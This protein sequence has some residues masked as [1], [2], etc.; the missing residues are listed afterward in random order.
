MLTPAVKNGVYQVSKYGHL[1]YM[2]MHPDQKYALCADI[3][4]GGIVWEP[5][6]N[7]SGT[8]DGL[9]N[10]SVYYTI[11]NFKLQAAPGATDV[12]FFAK[13]TGTVKNI[14][15]ADV[16]VTGT[17]TF[18]GNAGVVAGQSSK[19]FNNVFVKNSSMSLTVKNANVG[20]LVGKLTSYIYYGSTSGTMNVTLSGGTSYVGGVVGHCTGNLTNAESRVD[21]TVSG[22]GTAGAAGGIVG[23]E[24]GTA[25]ELNYIAKM[26]VNAD[27]AFAAGTLV[28][29][30]GG[31]TLNNSYNC[32]R[33][34]SVTGASSASEYCG[35][36]AANTAVTNC[37]TRDLSN[38]E[39]TLSATEYA[40]RKKVVDHMY[41]MCTIRWIPTKT[42]VIEASG[43]YRTFL[44]G[45]IYHGM[46][47]DSNQASLEKF[48]TYI[49]ADGTINTNNASENWGRLLGNDCA[50]AVYWAWAQVASDL[51]FTLT[52]NIVGSKGVSQVGSFTGFTKGNAT[53]NMC[54]SNGAATMYQAYAQIQMGDGLLFAPGH[55]RLASEAAYVFRNANGSIDPNKSYV[56]F[57]EQGVGGTTGSSTDWRSTCSVNTKITFAQLFK[58]N[59]IPITIDA[60]TQEASRKHS[61]T[62]SADLGINANGNGTGTMDPE[63]RFKYV[64]LQVLDG[65]Q[66]VQSQTVYPYYTNDTAGHPYPDNGSFNFTEFRVDKTKLTAGKTYTCKILADVGNGEL[67]VK[68]FSYTA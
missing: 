28:G 57:H 47:Y 1:L 63:G 68:E 52:S 65:N 37:L 7:F 56:L 20:L 64:T 45:E 38:I 2:Q 13:V 32:A 12:G 50:D 48:M 51:E 61:V 49:Q 58:A 10:T 36:Q 25:K 14:N 33:S 29:K 43:K 54:T 24:Q 21:I 42:T 19:N 40:L 26:K 59:Y 27:T 34:F 66:V 67:V 9:I 8:L 41:A 55:I 18:S 5:I 53:K 17:G 23:Y 15:F 46:P 22:N 30:L 16:T 62:V 44:A 6:A 4:L 60:F 35:A 11:S 3:D 31:G 39:D